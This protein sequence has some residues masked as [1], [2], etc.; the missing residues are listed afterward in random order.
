MKFLHDSFSDQKC[1]AVALI[2]VAKKGHVEVAAFLCEY[3]SGRDVLAALTAAAKYDRLEVVKL[4]LTKL[5][6]GDSAFTTLEAAAQRRWRRIVKFLCE[7]QRREA[8]SFL[9]QAVDS[10]D[11][12]V[13]NVLLRYSSN[14]Q[15]ADARE[16]ALKHSKRAIAELL[17]R[18]LGGRRR[19]PC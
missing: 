9:E 18:V 15:L 6:A 7:N 11:I 19:L 12:G 16:Y 1:T 3:L 2:L 13:A 10:N 17:S 14:G 4:L 5:R 8:T